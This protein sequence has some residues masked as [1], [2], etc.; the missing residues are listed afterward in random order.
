MLMEL[1]IGLK[2][3]AYVDGI[4]TD[5]LTWKLDHCAEMAYAEYMEEKE[6]GEGHQ[7]HWL[8]TGVWLA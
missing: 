1:L 6:L 8:R 2:G 3:N 7:V 4:P 5:N